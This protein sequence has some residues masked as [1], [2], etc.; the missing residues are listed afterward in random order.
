MRLPGVSFGSG[1]IGVGYWAKTI[2]PE[3]TR[4]RGFVESTS[5]NLSLPSFYRSFR[6]A[7]P[8]AARCRVNCRCNFGFAKGWRGAIT[9][10]IMHRNLDAGPVDSLSRLK[11]AAEQ[12]YT[13]LPDSNS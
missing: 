3:T 12:R 2:G 8:S 9:R 1:T 6:T 5:A 11:R 7:F 13:A 4:K 10:A